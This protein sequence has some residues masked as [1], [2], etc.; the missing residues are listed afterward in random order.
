MKTKGK[1]FKGLQRKALA[2]M[3][4]MMIAIILL[5][6]G[7]SAYQNRMLV[8]I[9]GQTRVAQQQSISQV[10]A[11]TMHQML[12][13]SLVS[14][15][16]LQANIADKD[17]AEVADNIRVLQA[18]AQDL[19]ARRDSLVVG[20]TAGGEDHALAKRVTGEIREYLQRGQ[21]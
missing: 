14:T 1:S 3:L 20:V 8:G 16:S 2:L 17:F 12:D 6:A 13:S 10:S 7:I 19:F 9:V 18:L 21:D 11:E 15:A 4:I 5:F